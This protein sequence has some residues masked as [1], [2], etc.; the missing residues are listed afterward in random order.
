MH[1]FTFTS[2]ALLAVFFFT[3]VNTTFAQPYPP[4]PPS[5]G[6]GYGYGNYG[7][8][9]A[10]G[11]AASGMA[12][13]I[14]AQGQT[15]LNNS[16][17]A[18]NLEQARSQNIQNKNASVNAYW[19]RRSTYDQHM[20]EQNYA[21]AQKRDAYFAKTLLKPLDAQQFDAT[22]GKIGWPIL[23]READFQDYRDVLDKTFGKLG[24]SGV[25]SIEEYT[26]ASKTIKEFRAAITAKQDSYPKETVSE[27]LR[28]LVALNRELESQFG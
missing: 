24:G 22:T 9:T 28:F 23:C 14:Q 8:S 2:I 11:S 18:I 10:A 21:E 12:N 15:N 1:R 4:P 16:M 7:A 5:Y 26:T 25:V 3:L 6:Y 20:A 13:V 27:A 17:A 19:D